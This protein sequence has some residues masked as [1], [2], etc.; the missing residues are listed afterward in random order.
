MAQFAAGDP[1]LVE[2]PNAVVVHGPPQQAPRTDPARADQA[3]GVDAEQ[4]DGLDA[5]AGLLLDLADDGVVG[6]LAVFRAA[7]RQHPLGDTAGTG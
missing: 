6:V 7:A 1:G 2:Q 4:G 5:V 3:V